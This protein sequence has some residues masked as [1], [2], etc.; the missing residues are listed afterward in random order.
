MTAARA[1]VCQR[2]EADGV[3]YQT[4]PGPMTMTAMARLDTYWDKDGQYHKHDP[5]KRTSE[6]HCSNGHVWHV[7][8]M[9]PC[10]SCEYGHTEP[11]VINR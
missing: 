5:N 8:A 1:P 11:Q 3:P 6:Y 9:F 4:R 2:C 7:I 10:R